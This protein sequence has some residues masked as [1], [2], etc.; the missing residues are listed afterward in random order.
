MVFA[1]VF[2]GVTGALR[3]LSGGYATL[4]ATVFLNG[5]VRALVPVN[6]AKGIA[7]WFR[8]R[9]LGMASGI[10][11]M[12]MGVGLTLASMISATYLSP[13]LGG[14]RNVLYL[15]GAISAAMGIF[16]MLSS[17]GSP[18]D[19]AEGPT[20]A[21]ARPPFWQTLRELARIRGIWLVSL[22]IMLRQ[23][24]IMGLTG[25][26]PLYLR[27]RGWA[28]SAADNTV[29]IFYLASALFVIPLCVL[30]DRVG[31]RKAFLVAAVVIT[32]TS[33]GLIPFVDGAIVWL[34]MGLT[35]IFMDSFM[36]LTSTMVLEMK[37]V[38][39][40]NAGTAVGIVFT[41]GPLG[42]VFAPPVG[43]SLDRVHSGLSFA[44][45]AALAAMSMVTIALTRETGW[46][47]SR[48]AG[49]QTT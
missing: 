22:T 45:W 13:L 42:G 46:R 11:G 19:G 37:G 17:P 9:G 44:F 38:S 48:R 41:I 15:Y 39:L 8:G 10:L 31:S 34:L 12:G 33:L 7:T 28:D 26:L 32:V 2:V 3:G 1:C 23:G 18:G 25:Y 43:N 36:S 40:L 30:S 27:G 16:W 49:K 21:P 6:T 20:P 4:A 5:L 24:A 35:G 14:W 47:K 29:A